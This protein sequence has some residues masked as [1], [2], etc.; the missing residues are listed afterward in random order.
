MLRAAPDTISHELAHQAREFSPCEAC[1]GQPRRADRDGFA[2]VHARSR[3]LAC[4]SLVHSDVE[5]RLALSAPSLKG[6][7]GRCSGIADDIGSNFASVEGEEVLRPSYA[8][9][10]G[11]A[12]R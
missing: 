11:C 3:C 9:P 6:S 4:R 2:K 1:L 8:H 5:F 12:D 7:R 10:G